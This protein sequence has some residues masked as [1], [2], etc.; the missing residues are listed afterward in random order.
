MAF[1]WDVIE[2]AWDR[3]GGLCAGCGKTLV[4]DNK[5]RGTRGAWQ[6]HHRKPISY[7]G[8]DYLSNCVLLCINTPCCHLNIG[9][10]GNYSNRVVLYDGDLPDLYAGQ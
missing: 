9:H 1:S 8:S 3:Q 5:D 2:R 4:W 7:E 10:N 6:A